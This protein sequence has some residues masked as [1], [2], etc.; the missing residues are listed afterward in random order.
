MF[1]PIEP[2]VDETAGSTRRWPSLGRIFFFSYALGIPLLAV[3]VGIAL[4]IA[5]N[6]LD[7]AVQTYRN[8]GP[9]PSAPTSTPCYTMVPGT[10]VT[11]S[12][13]RGKSGDT[14]DMT[15]QLPDG[16]RSTWAK[17]SWQ[18]EDALRVGAPA[19]AKFY[20]GALTTVY[21]GGVA[22]QTKDNP[23][24]KQSDMR[25]AA[26]IFPVLGLIIAGVSFF[27]RRGRK[28]TKV[29]SIVAIDPALP[30]AEQERLLRTALLGVPTAETPEVMAAPQVAGVT[31]PFT[32]RPHP[33]PTGRPWW[34]GLI[35]AAIA[36]PLLLLR[37]RTPAAIAQAVLAA[38]VATMLAAVVLHWLYRNRR[39][40]VVDDLSVRRVSMFGAARVVSRSDV[41][42]VACPVVMS[43]GLPAAEQ[44]LLLLDA[45]GRC[46]LGLPRYYSTDEEAA[47]LATALRVPL[48]NKLVSSLTT[49]PRLRRTIPGAVGWSE[50][51]PVLMT[52]VL[53]PPILVAVGLFVWM[54]DGFK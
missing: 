12:T 3:G 2:R 24:Y 39:M 36:M 26:V 46:L 20:Q 47:Q 35:I 33:I 10:L 31:L 14:T 41:A 23:I 11:F 25:L 50:A 22:I 28:Q 45:G 48:D 38:T 37:M 53:I 6:Q 5:S 1:N 4:L 19:Q 7:A 16:A 34:V 13:S 8:A 30:I 49:P 44:R 40:L 27:T 32:L 9:C 18:Q 15:L 54:L 43:F 51:H 29:G 52:M 21:V 17:T 42:R